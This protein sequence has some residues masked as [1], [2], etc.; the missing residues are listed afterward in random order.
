MKTSSRISLAGCT[1][2]IA[3]V[4]GLSGC[5]S[6]SNSSANAQAKKKA[7]HVQHVD[8]SQRPLTDMVAA[9]SASKGGPPVDMKF[10]LRETPIAAQPLDVDVAI[11]V[12]SPGIERISAHF[13]P[14]E[15]FDLVAGGE[16]D[17]PADKPAPG[18]VIRHAIRLLPKQDGIFSLTGTVTVD[19]ANDSMNRT[20]AIPVIVGE[21]IPEQTAKAEVADG[22]PAPGT[23]SKTH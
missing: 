3:L 1:V 14:G 7:T 10:E 16:L 12:S 22:P 23:G 13:Q 20:Y 11:V 18:T 17:P 4:L 8:P 5:G 2:A 6:S 15:G 21:G 19:T 9:V